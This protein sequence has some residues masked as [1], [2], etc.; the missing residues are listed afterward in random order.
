MNG[1][2][3]LLQDLPGFSVNYIATADQPLVSVL[4]PV[5]NNQQHLAEA[6]ESV[7]AQTYS[8]WD[9]T[10]VN[11][12]SSDNSKEVALR[13]AER[14]SRIRVVDTPSFLNVYASHNFTLRHTS[15]TAKY[16][17]VVFGDDWV[18]PRCLQEMVAV[19]EAH[20]SVAMVGAY[21]IEGNEVKW[22]GLSPLQQEFS[23]RYVARRYFLDDLNV[24][25]TANSLLFRADLV[26]GR[27]PFFDETHPHADRELCVSLLRDYNYG[28][29]PQVLTFT[30]LR[31]GSLNDEAATINSYMAGALRDLIAHGREFLTPVEYNAV[32]NREVALYYND[33]AIN[34]VLKRRDRAYWDYHTR[35][36]AECG[37]KFSRLRLAA[38]TIARAGRAATNP[39]ETY[40]KLSKRKA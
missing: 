26:R 23:G 27:V 4:T 13:Y 34:L 37:I 33:L 5:Y 6:I 9:Y 19:A 30:R 40:E 22:T 14:D 2:G 24:F 39:R 11:N 17:K 32:F 1:L 21:A 29:V 10:I 18:Y 25:G 12:C 36:L 20:A 31:K 15:S 38:A 7:L 3:S 8:N 16:C 35:R 28:F